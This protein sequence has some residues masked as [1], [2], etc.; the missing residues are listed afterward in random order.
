MSIKEFQHV[1]LFF[2][3]F[4]ALVSW[5]PGVGSFAPLC[6]FAEGLSIL[7]VENPF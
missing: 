5:S 6:E 1:V 2:C 4:W 3:I 7:V